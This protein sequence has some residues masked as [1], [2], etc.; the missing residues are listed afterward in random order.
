MITVADLIAYRR[1][2]DQLVERVVETR[3]PTG[4][5]E[6]TAVGY[7]SL[8]DGKHH[9]ALV[10]GDVAGADDVLVRVHSECLTGDV[11]HSLR[12][13]CGEQLE[14][15]LAMIE[16]EGSGVLLY[17]AQEGRGIGLLNKLKAYN[18]QD[19]GLDTVD[20]NLELGLP[21]RP[22]RLRHRR[23]DPRRP[24]AVDR[25]ASSP[26][27]RRRSAGWRAT[28]CRVDGAGADRARPEPAQR[29]L[30]ARQAR[31]HGPHAAPPGARAGRADG[32]RRGRPRPRAPRLVKFAIVVGRFYED[33]AERL[34]AGAQGVFE[35]GV[36]EA[37]VF[38]VPGAFEL[39]LAASYL[40]ETAA[41]P[42]SPASARSS[43]ARPTTTTTSAPRPPAGS[44]TSSCAPACRARSAC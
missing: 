11:F 39:P 23:A 38:D 9:V 25:S 2:H 24:R 31:P 20:A 30:P 33:L 1:K 10:K 7:R 19:Q 22:A 21:G 28:G 8:V 32:P 6:F 14:S 15:A 42:A 44:W 36:G 43:A 27:T 5:G 18:L 29:G 4:F 35:A 13:D 34:V 40:A 17:L 41:T 16:R 26:T 12:C 37:D 3:L